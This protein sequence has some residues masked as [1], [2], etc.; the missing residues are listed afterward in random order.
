ME[1]RGNPDQLTKAQIL[2]KCTRPQ[3]LQL[4]FSRNDQFRPGQ[5]IKEWVEKTVAPQ[6]RDYVTSAEV[7]QLAESESLVL[8]AHLVIIIGSDRKSVV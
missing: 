6:L 5:T 4:K 8:R 2:E 1:V 3:I 7:T